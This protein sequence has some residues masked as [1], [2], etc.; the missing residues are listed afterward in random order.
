MR[1]PTCLVLLLGLAL[2]P[3]ACRRGADADAADAKAT[4]DDGD[5]VI[6]EAEDD[7]EAIGEPDLPSYE[8]YEL[9]KGDNISKITRDRYGSGHYSRVVLL[10]NDLR[11]AQASSLKIGKVIKTPDI[12]AIYQ[13]EGLMDVVPDGCNALLAAR[14]AFIV[15]EQDVQAAYGDEEPSGDLEL[16]PKAVKALSVAVKQI[17][18]AV[19]GFE[20]EHEQVVNAPHMLID[21][22]RSARGLLG[23]LSDGTARRFKADEIHKHLGN[24]TAYAIIWARADYT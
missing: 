15:A 9:A 10:H 12:A 16:S 14:R 22:L 7:A 3:S 19:E 1:R 11:P 13:D 20:V 4:S 17:D 6:D 5:I 18:A 2:L 24:A 21:E 8:T 23:K